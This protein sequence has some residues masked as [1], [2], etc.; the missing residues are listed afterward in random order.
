LVEA[1]ISKLDDQLGIAIGLYMYSGQK[2]SGGAEAELRRIWKSYGA[3][4]DFW[5]W[6]DAYLGIKR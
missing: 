4:G 1:N 5:T 2:I 6:L 3:P